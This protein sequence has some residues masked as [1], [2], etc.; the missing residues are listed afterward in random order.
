MGRYNE[1]HSHDDLLAP[2][3]AQLTPFMRRLWLIFAQT[4]TVCLA[5]LFVV[6]TLRP[7]LLGAPRGEVIE[8]RER[9]TYAEPVPAAA[10]DATV[11][12]L[13]AV[14]LREAAARATPSVVNIL[15]TKE[16][17]V[18]RIAPTSDPLFR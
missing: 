12:V 3:L 16:A 2:P 5:V 18:P 7:D 1:T 17:K 14:S 13:P 8:L 9:I 4:A 15:T 6:S 10:K 11:R